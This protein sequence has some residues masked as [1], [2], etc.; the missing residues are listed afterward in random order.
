MKMLQG[1]IDQAGQVYKGL[2]GHQLQLWK[3][4]QKHLKTHTGLQLSQGST[5]AVVDAMTERKVFVGIGP[6][7]IKALRLN[8]DTVIPVGRG[9][10][11][12]DAG[13]ARNGNPCDGHILG[14]GAKHPGDGSILA[15]SFFHRI[16]DEGRIG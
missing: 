3:S 8:K 6:V 9:K 4:R 1:S 5:D 11:Q 16:G 10:G 15:E 13:P 12:K 7:D 2:A 14:S